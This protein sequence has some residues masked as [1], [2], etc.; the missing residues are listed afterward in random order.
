M[1]SGQFLIPSGEYASVQSDHP[2]RVQNE[3]FLL[4]TE[5]DDLT[6]QLEEIERIKPKADPPRKGH[7][8]RIS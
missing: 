8:F 7:L 1:S 6:N 5:L 2:S 3:L 4:Q